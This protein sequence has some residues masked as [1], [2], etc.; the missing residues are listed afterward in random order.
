MV[1]PALSLMWATCCSRV[2][3]HGNNDYSSLFDGATESFGIPS[4]DTNWSGEFDLV[5]E[6]TVL[7]MESHCSPYMFALVGWR[8][9]GECR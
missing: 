4:M 9:S 7:P 6:V 2:E 5:D 3:S 1:D 8:M